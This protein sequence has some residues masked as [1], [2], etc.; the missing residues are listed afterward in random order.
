MDRD[1]TIHE[2]MA[3][4]LLAEHGYE[5]ARRLL[6]RDRDMNSWGTFSYAFSNQTIKVLDRL[7][8]EQAV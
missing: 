3:S 7:H 5:E 8:E 6:A 1:A 4:R 2:E